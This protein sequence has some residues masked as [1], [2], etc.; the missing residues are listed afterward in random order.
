M[1]TAQT[2]AQ[3]T[4]SRAATAPVQRHKAKPWSFLVLASGVEEGTVM[5]NARRII[6][7]T[8]AHLEKC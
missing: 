1:Q 4:P 2:S 8:A 6:A 5:T 7:T 3:A